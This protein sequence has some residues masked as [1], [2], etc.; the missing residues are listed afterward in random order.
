MI[1]AL[2]AYLIIDKLIENS[3]D[4]YFD[5]LSDNQIEKLTSSQL[6]KCMFRYEGNLIR[7]RNYVRDSILKDKI[8]RL[9]KSVDNLIHYLIHEA[10]FNAKDKS[11]FI[12]HSLKPI[13]DV[14]SKCPRYER[15][16]DDNEIIN[17]QLGK[18]S[19]SIDSIIEKINND[20]EVFIRPDFEK[21][22]DVIEKILCENEL[23]KSK[24]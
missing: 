21:E 12:T 24:I 14:V 7:T 6:D 5:E 2:I 10:D 15:Q 13:V 18:I 8:D 1:I 23:R 3:D 22:V 4:S 11:Y 16:K 19:N 17:K 20:Y 9:V